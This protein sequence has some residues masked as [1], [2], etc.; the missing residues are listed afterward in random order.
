[1]FR[2]DLS[3][4]HEH[5]IEFQLVFLHHL[6]RV[7]PPRILPI[8]CSFSYA[9]VQGGAK[10]PHREWFGRFV[11]AFRTAVR[12]TGRR[13]CFI[14]SVDFAHIGPRYGDSFQPDEA[15]IKDVMR[16]D[17]E[18]LESVLSAD[19]AAFLEYIASE[20]DQRRICGFPALYTLL[21]L[22]D[23][24]KGRLLSHSHS[25]MDPSGSFVTYG[26]AVFPQD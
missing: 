19:S 26:S 22:L 12:E 16:K 17:G 4:R 8:L 25:V 10:S 14:A 11:G 23:G 7:S 5:T 13:A 21:H 6:F 20:Q 24:E 3:H 2:E 18:M 1:M 15:R 9:D